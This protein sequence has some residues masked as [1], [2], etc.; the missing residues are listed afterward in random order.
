MEGFLPPLW[1]LF[2]LLISIP[3]VVYGALKIK[4]IFEERPEQKLTVA[5][6]G[7]FVFVLSALKLPSV[8]GSSSHPT[9]TGLSTVLYGPAVTSLL[10]T[11]VLIFQALLLAHGGISTLGANIFS[12]G[13]AGPA[14]AFLVYRTL[15]KARASMSVSVFAAAFTADLMTYV[16]TS[17][18]L[19]LAY[20]TNGNFLP[21]FQTF[22]LVF[23]ITQIPLAILEGVLLVL[24]FNFLAESKPEVIEG[25]VREK[26][27]SLD[28]S[29]NRLIVAMLV[30]VL[31]VALVANA[32]V[33]LLGTDN[34]GVEIIQ[35]IDPGYMPWFENFFVPDK[36]LEML[37]F[38]LQAIIGIVVILYF[39]RYLRKTR[40]AAREA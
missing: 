4:R 20:P 26:R 6:S 13:I 35:Q 39:F 31:G 11:I 15:Q 3:F 16:V 27:P 12:M 14:L 19:A 28:R 5:V 36:S 29:K 23:A 18:Q 37:L 32:A 34:K 1:A 8:A 2:W 21:S 17:L 38:A 30:A 7:A 10:C 9:G 33:G 25:V 40:P 24:F 22:F